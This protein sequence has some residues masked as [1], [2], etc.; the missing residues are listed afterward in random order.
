[1]AV[2]KQAPNSN[3][4]LSIW[5]FFSRYDATAKL[6]EVLLFKSVL[7]IKYFRDH[8]CINDKYHATGVHRRGMYMLL[9]IQTVQALYELTGDN[10][11]ETNPPQ[12]VIFHDCIPIGI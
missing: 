11:K 6:N 5:G 7:Q 8:W 12:S 9:G 10:F 2:L 1:M 3:P 4:I